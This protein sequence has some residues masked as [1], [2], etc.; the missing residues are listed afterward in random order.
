MNAQEKIKKLF[1]STRI[2]Q[3]GYFKTLGYEYSQKEV[4]IYN[5]EGKTALFYT[6]KSNNVEF[7][8]HLVEIRANIHQICDKETGD[9]PLHVA[10]M[11]EDLKTKPLILFLI[12]QGADLNVLNKRMETPLAKASVKVLKALHLHEGA[13]YR[14]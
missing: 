10:F 11:T 1:F 8:Q 12:R 5:L 3:I 9:C 13:Q 14:K 2:N 6:C 4:N 7:T